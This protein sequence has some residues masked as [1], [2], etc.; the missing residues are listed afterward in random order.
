MELSSNKPRVRELIMPD[1][2][3]I[4]ALPGP[5]T[6]DAGNFI[7]MEDGAAS[8]VTFIPQRKSQNHDITRTEIARADSS[9]NN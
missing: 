5:P 4:G 9:K 1:R 8:P 6:D 2:Q 7:P 3:C